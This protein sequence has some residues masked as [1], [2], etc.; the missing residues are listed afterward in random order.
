MTRGAALT[1]MWHK[2]AHGERSATTRPSACTKPR[3]SFGLQLVL[4]EVAPL[5]EGCNCAWDQQETAILV[6]PLR[7]GAPRPLHSQ[8]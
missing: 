3:K 1:S 7:C 5:D 8:V 4:Y 2:G 6:I